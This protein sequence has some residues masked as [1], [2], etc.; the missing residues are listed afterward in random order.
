MNSKDILNNEE[1]VNIYGHI[2][3][4]SIIVI[5]AGYYNTVKGLLSVI[6]DDD[7]I[8]I[9]IV[10]KLKSEKIIEIVLKY[11]QNE[12]FSLKIKDKDE[13]I[14]I[15]LE[16]NKAIACKNNVKT[17]FTIDY[18]IIDKKS[19]EKILSGVLYSLKTKIKGKNYNVE[20]KIENLP[21]GELIMFLPLNW[22]E[23]ETC[24]KTS[25]INNLIERLNRLYFKGYTSLKWCK[26]MSKVLNCENSIICGNCMGKCPNFGDICYSSG[27]EGVFICGKKEPDMLVPPNITLNN[28][29]TNNFS[30]NNISGNG[31]T[32]LAI[33]LI[34]IIVSLLFYGIYIKKK[35]NK[36]F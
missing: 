31:V 28:E 19:R 18:S 13:Y 29:L 10:D 4:E 20:W 27:K 33:G 17:L 30:E 7:D 2:A 1:I 9:N 8:Q 6:N 32:F 21:N 5:G 12:N 34:I 35:Y 11:E 36:K 25:D 26:N 24:E 3:D 22:Y 23:N 14:G 16:N 15:K